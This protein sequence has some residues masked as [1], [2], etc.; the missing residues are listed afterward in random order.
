MQTLTISIFAYFSLA[1]TKHMCV[2]SSRWVAVVAAPK[3]AKEDCF[4]C[5]RPVYISG[6]TY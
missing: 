4:W 2:Y 6:L 3:A 1:S 5:N